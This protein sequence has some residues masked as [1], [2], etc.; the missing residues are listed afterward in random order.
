MLTFFL[1]SS[2]KLDEVE[3]LFLNMHNLINAFRPHQARETVI[4]MLEMQVQ[5]RREAARD[6]RRTIDESRLA[7]ERVHG[8]LH[9]STDDQVAVD[10]A[11][12]A[13]GGGDVKMENAD[14]VAEMGNGSDAHHARGA[15]SA[16]AL[17]PAQQEQAQVR[18]YSSRRGNHGIG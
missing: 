5:E 17:T 14:G 16:V 10:G 15:A 6:I 12:T 2:E 7:V 11:C 13:G 8:E 1:L 3:L 9:E 18:R 4:Q